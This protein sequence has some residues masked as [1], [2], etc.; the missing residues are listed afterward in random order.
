MLIKLLLHI[1]SYVAY[2]TCYTVS[3][4]RKKE[5]YGESEIKIASYLLVV[6]TLRYIAS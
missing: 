6:K 1:A 5:E 3:H 4:S 2:K